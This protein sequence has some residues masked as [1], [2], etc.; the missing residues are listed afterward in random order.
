MT[1][2]DK[3]SYESSPPCNTE[4]LISVFRG[5]IAWAIGKQNNRER[6]RENERERDL[7]RIWGGY[8]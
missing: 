3:G 2:E 1:Y 4:S 5:G 7:W 8:G 6:K